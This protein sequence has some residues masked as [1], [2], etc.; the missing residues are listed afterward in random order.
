MQAVFLCFFGS[1]LKNRGV[2]KR[3]VDLLPQGRW[4]GFLAGTVEDPAELWRGN[5]L[6]MV[7]PWGETLGPFPRRGHRRNP[8]RAVFP[9]FDPFSFDNSISG[10]AVSDPNHTLGGLTRREDHEAE[11]K[12]RRLPLWHREPRWVPVSRHRTM[13]LRRYLRFWLN[14]SQTGVGMT[15]E[16]S[17]KV[18]RCLALGHPF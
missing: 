10:V 1:S 5:R 2:K 4:Q 17:R 12:S 15:R 13:N 8:L 14:F 11:M 9:A 18:M 6:F 3:G 16:V 7:Y